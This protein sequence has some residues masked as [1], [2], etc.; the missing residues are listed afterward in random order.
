MS[1]VVSIVNTQAGNL[2]SLKASIERLGC[3]VEIAD[4]PDQ[5]RGERLVVPG[6]GHFGS[7]MQNL[8]SNNWLPALQQWREDN[9][10]L[11]G[12]C[13]GMQIFFSG[14]DESPAASGL[15]WLKGRVERLAFPKQPMVGWAYCE[16]SHQDF[17]SGMPYFVNSYAVRES[18]QCIAKTAYGEAFCAAVKDNN[19]V[20]F[21][22]HP[23]KSS[24]YGQALI[25]RALQ[26]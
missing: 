26:L 3:A 2:Y 15:G 20:G 17:R 14:S 25:Q 19:L 16:F 12:I 4:T 8:E 5:V 6:Q 23:E 9:K 7:V 10:P 24:Q 1:S 22:F 21:Q 13:V 18:E 11:L